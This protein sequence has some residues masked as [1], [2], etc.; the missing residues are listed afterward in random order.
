MLADAFSKLKNLVTIGI[1]DYNGRGR[2]REGES[3]TWRSYGWSTVDKASQHYQPR[4]SP[5]SVL[6]LIL[7]SLGQTS[8]GLERIEVFLRRSGLPDASFDLSSNFMR[9]KAI[10]VLSNLKA[11]LLSLEI[12]EGPTRFNYPRQNDGFEG[13]FHALKDFLKHTPL[14]EHLRLNF[15][16]NEQPS[17]GI[18]AF[19]T[20]LSTS[21]LPD[22]DIAQARQAPDP[23]QMDSPAFVTLD[24][25]T[26]LDL[27]MVH[28][29]PRTLLALVSKFTKLEELSLWKIT[30]QTKSYSPDVL[31]PGDHCLWS[32][33]L[34]KLSEDFPTSEN[35]KTF[36][37]GWPTEYANMQ[38]VPLPVRFED[39]TKVDGAGH[40][41]SE[42]FDDVIT[43]RKRVGSNICE[44][45]EDYGK[46]ASLPPLI[47]SVSSEDE[48]EDEDS[49]EG[50]G[51][52]DGSLPDGFEDG[53]DE[54]GIPDDL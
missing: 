28:V 13:A 15:D 7:Y 34:R 39:K 17:R 40:L 36:M 27:G 1:R 5:D 20:W 52:S 35:I 51:E 12:R 2:W 42:S 25:L 18:Q 46:R 3:A 26:T 31:E 11:L 10:P 41:T 33:F 9:S 43:Y 4:M 8:A 38:P 22:A 47:E 21:L 53:D 37:I 44:W 30:L 6:P 24:H 19:L 16:K 23:T 32:Y 14:L 29:A 45:L 54:A 50:D 49:Q 48:D